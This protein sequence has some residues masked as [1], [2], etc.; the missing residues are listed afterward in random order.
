VPFVATDD[1]GAS[2]GANLVITVTGTNFAPVVGSAS[3]RVSEEGLSG[4]NADTSGSTDT[5]NSATASGTIA[6]SDADGQALTVTLGAPST[7]LTS[8]GQAISWQ[9]SNGGHTLTGSAGGNTVVS[10][11]IDDAG[12][13]S[14][15]LAG[16]ID[17]PVTTAEDVASFGV[18]VNVSDG[19]T[20]SSGTLTIGVEDDSPVI[21]TPN[22]AILFNGTNASVTGDL[23]LSFGADSAGSPR[24]VF[25]GTTVDGSGNITATR[26]D[27]TGATV[28]T[29]YLTYNG[30]RLHYV[31]NADGSLTAASDTGNVAVFTVAGNAA[32]GDYT[33]TMLQALDPVSVSS[34][35]FGSVSAGN[36]GSYS[37]SDGNNTYNVTAQGFLSNGS[38]STVNTSANSFGVANQSLDTGERLVFGFSASNATVTSIGFTAQGLANGES[39][40]WRAYDSAGNLVGSGSLAGTGGGSGGDVSVTLTSAAN[41]GGSAIASIEFGAGS[42]TGYKLHLDSLAGNSTTLNQVIG[43]QAHGVDGD[44]DSTAAQGLSLSFASASSITGTTG[45]D[46]LG[47][48]SGSNTVSGGSG[49]D[50]IYG[51]AGGDTLTGGAGSDVFAWHLA[52]QGIAGTPATDVVTDFNNASGGDVLDL[53]DLLTG[54][55][56][57]NL[58][59]YLHFSTSGANTTISISSS[60]GFSGG[61][62]SGAVDQVITLQ[63][64]DLIGGMTTD[65]Q[66]IADLLNRGKLI[67]DA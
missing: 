60:G 6:V 26:T 43:L 31:S 21:A 35:V 9:T 52:D 36:N 48:G 27:S 1:Q 10:V 44:G 23:N 64:V 12:Q 54:E 28:N 2:H 46:A 22:S 13:Y 39:A 17:H 4:A 20:S 50:I 41:F 67:T 51:G 45:A 8:G 61:Y 62:S 30:S 47:G 40:T 14:V 49:D 58:S 38:T 15:T 32:R 3:V 56:S 24:A 16:P 25:A 66:V 42:S 5:T 59:N 57:G 19:I 11:T 37:F 34:V 53:R 55:S 18:V 7:A 63:G 29:G 65:A 33:V